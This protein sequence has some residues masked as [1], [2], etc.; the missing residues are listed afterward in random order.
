M[1]ICL[2]ESRSPSVTGSRWRTPIVATV[3]VPIRSVKA[4]GST[5]AF[6]LPMDKPEGIAVDA[7]VNL[8][9]IAAEKEERLYVYAIGYSQ[10]D[11]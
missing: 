11:P 7:A 6:P 8:V 1:P 4:S 3:A 2:G 10:Q 5:G 9:Y